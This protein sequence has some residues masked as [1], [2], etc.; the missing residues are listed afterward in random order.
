MRAWAPRVARWARRASTA[1]RTAAA[2]RPTSCC[3]VAVS[4]PRVEEARQPSCSRI[5][6]R[7]SVLRAFG[8]HDVDILQFAARHDAEVRR[9]PDSF[10]TQ[11]AQQIVDTRNR[12]A[13]DRYDHVALADTCIGSRTAFLD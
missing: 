7:A 13:I 11:N 5:F 12:D 9:F 2:Q 6:K 3:C 8:R 10:R 4:M 1:D